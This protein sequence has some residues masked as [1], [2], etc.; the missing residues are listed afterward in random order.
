MCIYGA[1]SQEIL[2][3]LILEE[4]SFQIL[5]WKYLKKKTKGSFGVHIS[6]GLMPSSM[7]LL[8]KNISESGELEIAWRDT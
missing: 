2:P 1:G 3:F 5:D 8:P 6:R 7:L 4:T